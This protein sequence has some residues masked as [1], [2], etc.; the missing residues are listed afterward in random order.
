MEL[1]RL[2]HR[3]GSEGVLHKSKSKHPKYYVTES[4]TALADLDRIRKSHIVR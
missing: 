4:R 3:F 1:N 2:G